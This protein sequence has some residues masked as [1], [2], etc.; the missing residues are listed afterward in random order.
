[1]ILKP[2]PE[3]RGLLLVLA[4][5]L[6]AGCTDARSEAA[7]EL[8]RLN[9]AMQRHST[10]YGRFP[11][12]LDASRPPSAA[13][14][15]YRA[16]RD[17]TLSLQS[18]GTGYRAAAR[19]KSWYCW[20]S[21]APDRKSPPDCYPLSAGSSGDSEAPAQA[22]KTLEPVLRPPAAAPDSSSVQNRPAGA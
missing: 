22:P 9:G 1:M 15:P 18:T 7:N 21:V 20:T 5:L 10:Q 11:D 8:T 13:N 6:A 2:N 12:T 19:R 3:L 14:L 4:A 16:E 17:V